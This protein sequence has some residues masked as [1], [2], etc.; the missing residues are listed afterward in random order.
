MYCIL[1]T[2][3]E[4][5]FLFKD[6][7]LSKVDQNENDILPTLKLSYDHLPS[8]LK[9]CFAYC[10]LFPKDS[11]ILKPTL[12]KMW[13]AQG[14]IRSSSQSQCPEDI[15]HDY[16]IE[17]LWRSFFQEVEE[18]ELGNISKFKIHD[19]MH[20]LAIQVTG[21]D[22]TTINSKVKVIEEKTRHV[23]F[24]DTL[25]SSSGIPSSLFKARRIRTFLLPCQPKH[26]TIRSN[27]ST[28]S[29]IVASFKFIRLLDLHNM[30]IKTI[31]SSIK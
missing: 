17:L 6:N 18:D 25:Y 21:S 28:Y 8:Y 13:M 7:E 15:G 3:K 4:N 1:R 24:E 27:D 26:D 16:F 22:C 30:G 31:P 14:F 19:L 20:D 2:Q 11:K 5:G 23:S 29:A 9:Q 10:C 12:I